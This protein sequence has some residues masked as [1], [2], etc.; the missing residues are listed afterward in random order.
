MFYSITEHCIES[1]GSKRNGEREGKIQIKN[2]I[3]II[4]TFKS[5]I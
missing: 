3:E 4:L 2:E 1:E 5:A